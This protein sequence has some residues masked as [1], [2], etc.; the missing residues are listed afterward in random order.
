[1]DVR[2]LI[3]QKSYE[4]VSKVLRRH[5]ITFIPQTVLFLVL[6]I[7][8]FLL[9]KLTQSNF[10]MLFENEIFFVLAVLISSIFY[11]S[12]YLF[13]FAQFI[14]F[15]L[16]VWIVTNDRI[17][18]IEQFGLFSRQISELDLF[19]VQD[20]TTTIKGVIPTFFQY[21]DV[22]IKTASQNLDIVFRQVGNPNTVR[23]EIL[24]LAEV[25]RKYHYHEV[26][27]KGVN[28]I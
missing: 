24:N 17:I 28:E 4:R 22:S 15:Y 5:P 25:D 13:F 2:S 6:L 16:D 3:H 26:N 21:G 7:T 11:L 20:I 12:V 27:D 9:Y 23:H 8:P 14:D 1:M 19:R 10:P 18:D